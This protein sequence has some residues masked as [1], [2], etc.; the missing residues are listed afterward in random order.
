M[1]ICVYHPTMGAV[2]A[3]EV[4]RAH[5][6]VE[7]EVAHDVTVDPPRA[8][9][10]DV[11]LANTLLDGLLARCPRLRWLHLTGTGVDHLVRAEPPSGL[12]VTNSPDVP[13]RAVAEFAWMGLLAL[14]KDASASV[15]G[16]VA[17]DGAAIATSGIE[18]KKQL[19]VATAGGGRRLIA[20]LLRIA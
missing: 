3:R 14:A 13:A 16:E 5:P 19:H 12:L 8:G 15:L 1:R 9:E 10:L 20:N 7:L 18:P 11:L 6:D 2:V 4:A 17:N